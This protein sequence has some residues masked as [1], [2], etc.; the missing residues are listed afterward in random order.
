MQDRLFTFGKPAKGPCFSD[1]EK[2]TAH[3]VS[4]FRYGIN[5]FILSPG[6][7]GKTSLVLKAIEELSATDIRTMP[8]DVHNCKNPEQFCEKLTGAVLSQTA[9]ELDEAV[10]NAKS[11]RGRRCELRT[12]PIGSHQQV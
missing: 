11:F 7:W 9:G 6:R 2:E 5:A 1:R 4:N 3:L 10:K 12:V 8:V